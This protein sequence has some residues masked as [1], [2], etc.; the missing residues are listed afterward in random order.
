MDSSTRQ[1]T[2]PTRRRRRSRLAILAGLVMVGGI[3]A[4]VQVFNQPDALALA[5]KIPNDQGPSPECAGKPTSGSA[6]KPTSGSAGNPTS[7][8]AGPATA[9]TAASADADRAG[10]RHDGASS[11]PD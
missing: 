4:G 10:H 5:A 11:V 7:A 9:G 2:T 3:L 1:P 8:S 6:G